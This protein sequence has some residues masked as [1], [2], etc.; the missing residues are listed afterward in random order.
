MKPQGSRHYL[1][2]NNRAWKALTILIS[3]EVSQCKNLSP[4]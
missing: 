2:V 3:Q 4:G 1:L